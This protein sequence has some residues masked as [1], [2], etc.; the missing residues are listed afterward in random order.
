[1]TAKKKSQPLDNVVWRK[2][3]ELT[4][5]DYN[6][7]KVAKPEMA[8]LK[9]SILE[10]GWTQPI[11]I[12]PDM[13]IVDGFHRWTTSA[14]AEVS[15]M[16][17][18]LIP[19]VMLNPTSREQQKMATIRHNRA[20]GT[21]KVLEMSTIIT[22]LVKQG[23]AGEEIMHRLG[24]EKEEVTRLLF[25]AGIPKSDVFKTGEFSKAWTPE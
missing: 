5:N 9:I 2:R 25:R 21:H 24:M 4:S 20:R 22:D 3:E 14:D 10:D 19:T 18:G 8:L 6:P 15:A 17:D 13:S 1:M 23:I 11:V 12:N 7:N 16:T